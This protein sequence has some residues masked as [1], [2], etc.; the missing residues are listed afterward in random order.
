MFEICNY[1]F[2]AAVLCS[3]YSRGF[4]ALHSSF[5]HEI[6][7]FI[8]ELYLGLGNW[9]WKEFCVKHKALCFSHSTLL[10]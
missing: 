4:G 3:R 5:S 7:A 1:C 2:H 9:Q 10:S 8:L 6:A